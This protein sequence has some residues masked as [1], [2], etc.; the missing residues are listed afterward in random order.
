MRSLIAL[1]P[2]RLETLAPSRLL[3]LAVLLVSALLPFGLSATPTAQAQAPAEADPVQTLVGRL[4]LEKYK[5]TVKG[6]T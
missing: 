3:T 4:D 5:A 6:L 1:I 2:F